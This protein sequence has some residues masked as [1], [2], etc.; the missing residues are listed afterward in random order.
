MQLHLQVSLQARLNLCNMYCKS[1]P[2]AKLWGKLKATYE[3]DWPLTL[4]FVLWGLS[5]VGAPQ[6]NLLPDILGFNLASITEVL[7]STYSLQ[8]LVYKPFLQLK[9]QTWASQ[10]LCCH[11]H[12]RCTVLLHLHI[13]VLLTSYSVNS[14]IQTEQESYF[15]VLCWK[16]ISSPGTLPPYIFCCSKNYFVLFLELERASL[17]NNAQ[18]GKIECTWEH[19]EYKKADAEQKNRAMY[20]IKWSL[21]AW[22]SDLARSN[23]EGHLV[24]TP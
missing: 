4:D 16:F 5:T 20:H 7:K 13:C 1:C 2:L 21:I 3:H 6:T 24:K 10:I 17:A 15:V 8:K 18:K 23:S 12:Q 22:T 19:N 14:N 11:L 9:I